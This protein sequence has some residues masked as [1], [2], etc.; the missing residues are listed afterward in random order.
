MLGCC[1]TLAL[2]GTVPREYHGTFQELTASLTVWQM[3]TVSEDSFSINI[4][5]FGWQIT[6][7]VGLYPH[8][9]KC[10]IYKKGNR[11]LKNNFSITD[12]Q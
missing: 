9:I 10:A 11:V 1:L 12:A 2:A 8:S 5:L 7:I 6:L 4:S 3:D